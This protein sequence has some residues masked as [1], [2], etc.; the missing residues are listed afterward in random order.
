MTNKLFI[1]MHTLKSTLKGVSSLN[2]VGEYPYDVER[3]KT[4]G[5]VPA[6]LIQE[7]DE[8]LAE[9]ELNKSLNKSVSISLWLYH[10]TKKST[11][12]TITDLQSLIET[13]VLSDTFYTASGAYCINWV[14]VEKGEHLDNYDGY[15]VGYHNEH[16]IRKINLDVILDIGRD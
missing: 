13:T 11:I 14:G 8:D 16:M 3:G 15:S 4:S 9:L 2:Y 5:N 12:K 10:N 1:F 7:G 6:V